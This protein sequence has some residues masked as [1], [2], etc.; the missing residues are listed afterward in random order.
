MQRWYNWLYEMKKKDEEKRKEVEHQK[1]V[2]S[3]DQECGRWNR[4][5]AQNYKAH[6]LE[7]RIADAGEGRRGCQTCGQM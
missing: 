4:S 6:R 7:R 5:F 2:Q 1:V 3:Y